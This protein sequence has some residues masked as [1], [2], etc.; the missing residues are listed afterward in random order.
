[1]QLPRLY[2]IGEIADL[3]GATFS[4]EKNFPISGLSEIHMVA[5]GDLSFV[6][7]PKYYEKA[8]Q[9]AAS[10]IIINIADTP[11]NGKAYIFSDDPFRDFNYLTRH[12]SR[13]Q[14][15]IQPI[16]PTATIGK[17]SIIQPGVF[18]GHRVKIGRDCIIHSNVS[19]YD[20]V[21]IGDEVIVHA[22]TV[23]GADAL[24]FKKRD[25]GYDKLHSC[26]NVKIGNRVEIGANCTIDRGVSSVTTIGDGCKLDNLVHIAHD[27]VIGKNCLFAAQV[28]VAGCVSIEDDVILWGQ[29]GVQ[30]NVIIGKSAIILGQSGVTKS[31]EGGKIYFGTPAYE[32]QKKL[33]ELACIKRLPEIFSNGFPE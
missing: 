18:I 13:F 25:S 16:S 12:F 14:P 21:E 27:T 15:S 11:L 3:I 26:G 17:G 9:S 1:M 33:R 29:V 4:G 24:Y 28:G 20:E 23:I 31:L 5:P 30:K 19:I 7:H 8:Y 22:N 2:T 6:D 10:V 32:A